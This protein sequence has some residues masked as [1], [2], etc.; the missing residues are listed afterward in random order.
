MGPMKNWGIRAKTLI[1][2]LVIMLIVSGGLSVWIQ[3]QQQEQ[4][5]EQAKQA[6]RAIQEQIMADRQVYTERVILKLRDDAVEYKATDMK[7]LSGQKA[8]PLPASF[9]H[10]TSAVVNQKGIHSADLVALFNINPD[11]APRTEFERRALEKLWENRSEVQFTVEGTGDTAKLV[12][13]SADV[14]SSQACVTCHNEHPASKK[15]DFRLNDVMG[16]LVVKI[17]LADS[18]KRARDTATLLIIVLLGGFAV[19]LGLIAFIQHRAITQ[20]LLALEKA[21]EAISM[22]DVDKPIVVT[23]NDEVGSLAK[24]FERMRVSLEQIM[25]SLDKD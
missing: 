21:A 9:V 1:P 19:V 6:A 5:V 13:I 10:L 23:T 14:A 24:A 25:K 15:K 22:G 8:I 7:G 3:Q 11:K 16:G 12:A 2:S 18:F 4:A 20:P 17:P